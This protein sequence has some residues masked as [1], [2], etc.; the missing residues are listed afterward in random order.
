MVQLSHPY[1]TSGKTIALTS[2]TFVGRVMSLLFNILFRLGLSLQMATAA[3]KLRLIL[4][5][6]KAMSN[7]DPFLGAVIK[8]AQSQ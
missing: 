7:L 5:G 4:L 6:R 8:R 1:M 3:M 2:W